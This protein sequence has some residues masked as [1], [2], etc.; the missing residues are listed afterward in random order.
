MDDILVSG[1]NREDHFLNLKRLLQRLLKKGLRCRK[2]KCQFAQS[3]V[4]YLGHVLSGSGISKGTK[5]DN[6][7]NMPEPTDV[8]TLRSF[9]G[10]VQFYSKFL[11]PSFSTT[12]APL[13]RLLR[14][15]VAWKWTE[16]EKSGFEE[17][18]HLL[19][20]DF[21]LVHFD[22]SLP[23]GIAYDASSIGIGATLF[24]RYPNGN[25]RPIA[26][27]SKLLTSS[28]QNYSQ[29]QKEAL[30]IVSALKKIFQYLFGRTFILVTDHKPLLALFGSD[31]PVPG[32]A[33]HRLARWALFLG[34]FHHTIKYN[35]GKSRL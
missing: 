1:T 7:I 28:Q 29:I 14:D 4:E 35:Q 25:E 2:E 10:S 3:E 21:V 24:H 13:Y 18:K 20:S 33:A 8:S 31:K 15:K 26:N 5:M 22:S 16:L 11:P 9:L 27:V 6:V 32:L 34:Q 30:A 23:L 17:L 19:S 12:A